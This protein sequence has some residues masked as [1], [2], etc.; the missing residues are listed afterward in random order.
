MV[1][2][3]AA[4]LDVAAVDGASFQGYVRFAGPSAAAA[5]AAAAA[6]VARYH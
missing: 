5:A 6:D 4:A 3:V 1:V 2:A